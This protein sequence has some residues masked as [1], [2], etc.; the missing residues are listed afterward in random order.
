[1]PVILDSV[2]A[3]VESTLAFNLSARLVD[4]LARIRTTQPA[5]QGRDTAAVFLCVGALFLTA[6]PSIV[7][8]VGRTKDTEDASFAYA[9]ARGK[10][11]WGLASSL[12]AVSR[13][14]IGMASH[15]LVLSFSRIAMQQVRLSRFVVEPRTAVPVAVFLY[16]QRILEIMFVGIVLSCCLTTFLPALRKR[17]AVSLLSPSSSSGTGSEEQGSV[18]LLI[19]KQVNSLVVNMQRAFAETVT[20]II[21]DVQARK[22]IVLLGLCMLPS[23]SG[24]SSPAV[25]LKQV[26]A[27]FLFAHKS[28]SESRAGWESYASILAR[29]WIAGLSTAWINTALGFII[30]DQQQRQKWRLLVVSQ[31]GGRGATAV[32]AIQPWISVISTTSLAIMIRALV[33]LFPGIEVFQGY[34][35]WSVSTFALQLLSSAVSSSSSSSS[36]GNNFFTVAASGLLFYGIDALMR[37]MQ[38][39]EMF[40]RARMEEARQKKEP[41]AK[42]V[43]PGP[44]FSGTLQTLQSIS[45]IM[46]TNSLVTYSMDAITPSS[47]SATGTGSTIATLVVGL[48]VA[49]TIVQ[50]MGMHTRRKDH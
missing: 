9:T 15:V 41:R 13:D 33:P 25:G 42:D 1:M 11:G 24:S 6:V 45:V 47:A 16:S 2:A 22:M 8:L 36:S 23:M 3:N 35:E 46:F 17:M 21:P 14:F 49:K 27:A 18:S 28:T 4:L 39:R 20:A 32:L 7:N 44:E 38:R 31:Q 43:G 5:S 19:G 50:L 37:D 48:V 26:E 12:L 30:P 29:I 40:K 10:K 34:I